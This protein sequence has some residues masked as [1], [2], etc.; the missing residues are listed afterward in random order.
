METHIFFDAL[1]YGVFA[2]MLLLSTAIGVYFAFFTKTKQ[3]NTSEYLMGS[4][5]MGIFP[6]S[7]SLIASY[8]SGIALIGMPAEIYVYGTQYWALI[9]PELI[10]SIVMM[11]VYIPVFYSLQ[12]V[13]SYEYLNVRFNKTVRTLGS[14][15]FLIKMLLYIPIVIYVPAL[16][17][18]QVTG[19][20]I[21]ILV[22]IVSVVCIFYTTLGG[23]KAVVWTD[24]LQIGLMILGVLTVATMGTLDVGGPKTVWQRN[25]ESG[26]IEFFNFDLDPRTRHT[27]WNIVVGKFFHHLAGCTVNQAM[28][29]RCLAMPTLTKARITIGIFATGIAFFVS[30]SCYT[31]LVIFAAFYD[32]DPIKSKIITKS[33]QILPYFVMKITSHIPGLPGIFVSGVFSAALSTMSTG[34]NSMT[35]VILQD[36]IRPLRKKPMSEA[37]AAFFM[38]IIV[39]VLGITLLILACVVDKLG[40]LIQTSGSLSG[41]TAGTLLGIFTLGMLFPWANS[42][43]ALVGGISSALFVGW[44][45]IGAQVAI[46]NKQIIFPQKPVSLDGCDNE[47]LY[48]Y[49]RHLNSTFKLDISDPGEPFSL[50]TVSYVYYACFGTLCA[51]ILG[52]IVSFLTGPSDPKTMDPRL[53]SPV[54]HRYLNIEK[55]AGTD[56]KLLEKSEKGNSKK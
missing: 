35:G 1:D 33:D 5:K 12:I 46:K 51:V 7:M 44:I 6:I 29:Q 52:L 41:I 30:L 16:A 38:K 21:Y 55:P 25:D 32:C 43:G 20:S 53:F 11:T 14:A 13:S 50:Y 2:F 18:S 54:I 3:N 47:T 31:G 23:I 40:G 26:R 22:P 10:T 8:I 28:V 48:N 39:V 49:E 34:L 45:S 19:F 42:T 37:S 56:I 15:L 17:F 27:F 4:K 24:T 36:F 9:I